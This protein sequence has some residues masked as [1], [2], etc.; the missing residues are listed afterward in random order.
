LIVR[1]FC[2]LVAFL[3]PYLL[4]AQSSLKFELL[5]A[6]DGLSHNK[7]QCILQDKQGYLW[8]GTVYGLN[9]Y[10]GYSFKVFEN[11]PGDSSTLA[12]NDIISLYQDSKGII[13]IGT[14]TVLSSYDPQTE[15][16]TN[17]NLPALQGWIYDFAEDDDG[18]LWLATGAGLFAFNRANKKIFYN[19]T[20][21][22]GRENIQNILKDKGDNNIF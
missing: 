6:D 12:N 22:T 1:Q 4:S 2:V 20:D 19:K 17:Y 13:W 15:I 3:F 7:V 18:M 8:F 9:R 5:T 14:S 16:F 21:S 11:V 10:D